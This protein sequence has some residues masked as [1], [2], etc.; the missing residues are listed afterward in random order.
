MIR[1][2][3]VLSLVWAVSGHKSNAAVKHS[4]VYSPNRNELY[5][6]AFLISKSRLLQSENNIRAAS[7]PESIV[8]NVVLKNCH[9]C[10]T[11]LTRDYL[12]FC[13]EHLS[14]SSNV[15]GYLP[16]SE[17]I[18]AMKYYS[19]NMAQNV[20][21]IRDSVILSRRSNFTL[22]SLTIAM[23]PFSEGI[24]NPGGREEEVNFH[25]RLIRRSYFQ[26][27]FY[28]LYR[29]FSRVVVYVSSAHDKALVLQW[30][31]P[32][33]ALIDLSD[34]LSDVSLDKYFFFDP[35]KKN[36][37]PLS[38]LL[39][40]YA[41]LDLISKL[42]NEWSGFQYIYYTEGDQVLHMR[43]QRALYHM[44]NVTSGVVMFT[45]HRMQVN[46]STF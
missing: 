14:S 42:R 3:A 25:H 29:Y 43:K 24:A 19:K 22:S 18:E 20:E 34:T 5:A 30:G 16:K 33:Y 39:P 10:R 7:Y 41:L 9:N 35:E 40:K 8:L 36:P 12:D 46:L 15:V 17:Q 2:I 32:Y 28:S 26:A 11:L 6:G 44:M 21:D 37:R 13:I 27:T 31:L 45:P 38:Q 1:C 23:I 4:G